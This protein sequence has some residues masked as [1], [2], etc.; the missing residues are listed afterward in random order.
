[1]HVLR[2]SAARRKDGTG[3]SLFDPNSEW[4]IPL[5]SFPSSVT[6]A[7]KAVFFQYNGTGELSALKI[8]SIPGKPDAKEDKPL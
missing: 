1:M 4:T 6:V 7:I 5:Y 3:V 8:A 2:S